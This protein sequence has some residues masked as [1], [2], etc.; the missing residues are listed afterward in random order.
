MLINESEPLIT[1]SAMLTYCMNR[2]LERQAGSH[3]T[4]GSPRVRERRR[5]PRPPLSRPANAAAELLLHTAGRV[6][7]ERHVRAALQSAATVPE[8]PGGRRAPNASGALPAT[9]WRGGRRHRHRERQRKRDRLLGALPKRER[10]VRERYGTNAG[11][12]AR[13][14]HSTCRRRRRLLVQRVGRG[15]GRDARGPDGRAARDQLRAAARLLRRVL[16]APVVRALRA[17]ASTM[18]LRDEH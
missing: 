17:A 2:R 13:F 16:R 10:R 7:L 12:R 4:H 6:R 3:E 5:R 18:P 8:R 15:A 11:R 14:G 9:H 1:I